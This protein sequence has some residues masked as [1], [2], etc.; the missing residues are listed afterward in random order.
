VLCYRFVDVTLWHTVNISDLTPFINIA[1]N[2]WSSY[3]LSLDFQDTSIF[4]CRAGVRLMVFNDSFNNISAISWCSVLLVEE[5]GVPREN[6]VS[7]EYI[8]FKCHA[9]INRAGWAKISSSYDIY[10][11]YPIHCLRLHIKDV[12]WFSKPCSKQTQ[13]IGIL[14]YFAV[15]INK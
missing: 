9:W 8:Y 5:I 12:L 7:Q 6:A 14:I 10:Y 4:D 3:H 13:F 1:L 11:D 15:E 2:S